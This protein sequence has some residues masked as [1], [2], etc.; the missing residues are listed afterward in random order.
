MSDLSTQLP[1][2]IK[3]PRNVFVL[4]TGR[5]GSLTFA[6][7]CAHMT[8]FTS[9][10][11]TRCRE[12][13]DSRLAYPDYH[14]EVD[15]RLSW[16]LGRLEKK[17]GDEAV[18]VHLFRDAD[19]VAR[20][21][22]QRWTQPGTIVYNH[23]RGVM[24]SRLL[25]L[26]PCIDYVRTVTEN[27]EA[28]LETKS[29]VHVIDIADAH[30]P[31]KRFWHD[32][33]AEGDLEAAL[34]ELKGRHNAGDR[35]V[36][37]EPQPLIEDYKDKCIYQ[38]ERV[39]ELLQQER[40]SLLSRVH[41]SEERAEQL[42]TSQYKSVVEHIELPEQLT[43]LEPAPVPAQLYRESA[44]ERTRREQLEQNFVESRSEQQL[45]DLAA[46]TQ[47]LQ[48]RL[49]EAR[50]EREAALQELNGHV[51]GLRQE[52]RQARDL[53]EKDIETRDK[54][55][56]KVRKQ[57]TEANEKVSELTLERKDLKRELTE[58][59]KIVRSMR[60]SRAYLLGNAIVR[61]ARSPA[62]WLKMP[63][64]LVAVLRGR[65]DDGQADP[66]GADAL[67]GAPRGSADAAGPPALRLGLNVAPH[68]ID[69]KA[70][71][72][73]IRA[74]SATSDED[75]ARS[76]SEYLAGFDLAP[77][78]ILPGSGKRF[79]RITADPGYQVQDG[80]KVSVIIPAY[81]A[82]GTIEFAVGSILRQTWRNLEVV[83]V[84][85]ASED[86]TW[87]VLEK[88]AG[89]DARI[90]LL[91]NAVNVGPYVSK[92]RAVDFITGQYLTGHDSDDWAH[93]QR[94]ERHLRAMLAKSLKG[95]VGY[96]LRVN[97]EAQLS[98][99]TRIGEMSFDGA[100]RMAMISSLF[101]T[102]EFRR[103]LGHWDSVRFGADSE[104]ISRARMAFGKE[105]GPVRIIGMICLD[106][107]SG[108]TNDPKHGIKVNGGL[109]P[110]RVAYREHFLKWHKT[111]SPETTYLAFPQARR[112]FT[113]PEAMLVDD[114]SIAKVFAAS[115]TKHSEPAQMS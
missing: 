10:H 105:F 35:P 90:K 115:E 74:S 17:Y 45:R 58:L 107:E 79:F 89:R 55:I 12:F 6:N 95:S 77:L 94:I 62:G 46:S 4:S 1:A 48:E 103:R 71:S 67:P 44:L 43:L 102:S 5:C 66:I 98:Q 75:W 92:N 108:L 57:L 93:P 9:G 39:V 69:E 11:E 111:L 59:R 60:G 37:E 41:K 33:G 78:K 31:F 56:R 72:V 34:A 88:L 51:E 30:E 83:I 38:L 54:N 87:D 32:I 113:A 53:F 81:N 25:G 84:D 73:L 8:N 101:D 40:G 112:K 76:V 100:A 97:E 2:V 16:F 15:N 49:A 91:R 26:E 3:R 7:A 23:T 82:A 85:D 42:L 52:L 36:P 20:S 104:L 64:A 50:S 110:T 61:N 47:I 70:I 24:K 65:L 63:S 13:G 21:Y 28:F 29:R 27:I 19:A 18:Y 68:E 96:M 22:N 106:A 99:F 86:G 114:E 14:I 109:S 80:P